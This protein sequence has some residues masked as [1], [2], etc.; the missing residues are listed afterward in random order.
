V[1]PHDG[2]NYETLLAEADHRMYRD[3]ALRRGRLSVPHAA[4]PEFTTDVHGPTPAPS[5]LSL[6]LPLPQT[7]AT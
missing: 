3:K 1:Y 5:P 4:G 6:T 7:A 2:A